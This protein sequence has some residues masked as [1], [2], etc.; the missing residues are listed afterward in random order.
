MSS[1]Q[2]EMVQEETIVT[3][4]AVVSDKPLLTKDASKV[5]TSELTTLVTSSTQAYQQALLAS[6]KDLVTRYAES[7]KKKTKKTSSS[8]RKPVVTVR[9]DKVSAAFRDNFLLNVTKDSVT[10]AH[11]LSTMQNTCF[12]DSNQ[13]LNSEQIFDA[14]CLNKMEKAIVEKVFSTGADASLLITFDDKSLLVNKIVTENFVLTVGDKEYDISSPQIIEEL[15]KDEL[16]VRTPNDTFNIKKVF[17]EAFTTV[18]KKK[19]TDQLDCTH[20]KLSDCFRTITQRP[21]AIYCCINSDYV[22]IL[23][24]YDIAYIKIKKDF[25]TKSSLIKSALTKRLE[26]KPSRFSQE[27]QEYL[28]QML[29]KFFESS[30]GINVD[31]VITMLKQKQI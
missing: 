10:L 31:N 2:V 6:L 5:L 1:T 26:G 9:L 27:D 30:E 4:K 8:T 12:D 20:S 14:L 16:I 29:F 17:S 21:S 23:D 24:K 19:I 25:Y 18:F 22:D 28:G 15:E 3:P 13:I 11:L 7:P